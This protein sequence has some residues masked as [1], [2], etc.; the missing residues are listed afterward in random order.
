MH[1]FFCYR[2]ARGA[3]IGCNYRK[4]PYQRS[5][6][7]VVS[8]VD[9]NEE[10]E[11]G[12]QSP[13][14]FAQVLERVR[15]YMVQGNIQGGERVPERQLCEML[16]VSRTPLREA[17]KALASE[18]L[19]E[20]LP[21]R[22]ARVRRIGR[23]EIRELFEILAG[24]EAL[25]GRLAAERM[26]EKDLA[27]MEALHLQMYGCYLARDLAD[28]FRLNQRIHGLI[29]KATENAAL[30]GTYE[31]FTRRLAPYRY[32]ANT[33]VYGARWSDAM[34]EHE[35]ML[36]FLKRRDGAGMADLMYHH[37][38]HKAETILGLMQEA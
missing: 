10:N 14:V 25:A 38:M 28:Y 33:D 20:L 3:A 8:E 30:A 24:L 29:V 6:G 17:L 4:P 15:D 22:G 21:N 32:A 35:A 18:G 7:A 5:R 23:S 13:S 12:G 34:R 1:A 37:L 36:E 9:M 16:G 11:N 19:V 2:F 26:S 27:E 31:T